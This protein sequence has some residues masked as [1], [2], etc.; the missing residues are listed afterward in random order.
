M[1]IADRV[2]GWAGRLFG[3]TGRGGIPG[4]PNRVDRLIV[5]LILLSLLMIYGPGGGLAV[6]AGI[7][8]IGLPIAVAMWL[9]PFATLILLCWRAAFL[10]LRPVLSKTLAIL[11]GLAV[12][13]VGLHA[14]DRSLMHGPHP[15]VARLLAHDDPVQRIAPLPDGRLAF[16]DSDA[17]PADPADCGMVCRHLLETPYVSELVVAPHSATPISVI[18]RDHNAPCPAG[19]TGAS[20]FTCQRPF[21]GTAPV[22]LTTTRPKRADLVDGFAPEHR[23]LVDTLVTD[24]DRPLNKATRVTL[25]DTRSGTTTTVH[26]L[27]ADSAVAGLFGLDMHGIMGE[28]LTYGPRIAPRSFSSLPDFPR[29]TPASKGLRGREPDHRNAHIH[30]LVRAL[31]G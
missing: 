9:A 4:F 5:G 16:A 27:R 14:V 28:A 8:I 7:S 10:L 1:Q 24:A 3:R 20:S 25:R 11:G 23:A 30:L 13:L 31:D 22:T 12:T 21:T 29:D 2:F 15:D 17:D 6:I 26:V 18:S 19:W